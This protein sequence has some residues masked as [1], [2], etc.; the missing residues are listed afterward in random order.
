MLLDS[1]ASE[2]MLIDRE[3]SM[4]RVLAANQLTA[5]IVRMNSSMDVKRI[6]EIFMNAVRS[7]GQ[8]SDGDPSKTSPQVVQ[9]AGAQ[10]T[11]TRAANLVIYEECGWRMGW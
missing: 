6:S 2:E 9:G 5:S 10:P 1:T 4:K 3:Y 11:P 7:V 8:R